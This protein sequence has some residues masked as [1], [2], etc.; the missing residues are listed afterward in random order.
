MKILHICPTFSTTTCGIGA[1]ARN[2]LG[3]IKQA[4][5][6][7]EQHVLEGGFLTA[8][9]TLYSLRPDVCH[10][11]L[12][13]GFCSAQRLQLLS[14]AC[15]T[16]QIKLL[17]TFHTLACQPHN[18]V[19]AIRLAHTPL[20]SRYGEFTVIPSGIPTVD[21]PPGLEEELRRKVPMGA[22]MSNQPYLFF[23]QAHPH[24]QLLETLRL[25]RQKGVPLLCIV[26]RPVQGDTAYYDRCRAEAATNPGVIWPD[27]F[28]ND[29]EVV[30]AARHCRAALF[31][32]V[33]Y[34]SIGVSAAVK[35]LL[36]CPDLPLLT[37]YA[38]HFS[39][40]P[41]DGVVSR[42]HHLEDMLEILVPHSPVVRQAFLD[43][44]SFSAVA[45]RHL[46]LYI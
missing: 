34:G 32:Y 12:E 30:T 40:L 4:D 36:N 17:V 13:Y 33:E 14:E 39:D 6:T 45:Q 22:I 8:S 44:T 16:L 2:L 15:A 10:V 5:P 20:C 46:A 3:A 9:E 38:S 11:Q 37:T 26:S 25:V 19:Q 27:V 21:I 23:G 29:G 42:Y 18:L 7:A 1:Y 31:P 41:E 24:K 28:L 35:L 43:E